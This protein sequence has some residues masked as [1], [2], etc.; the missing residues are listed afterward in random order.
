VPRPITKI[1]RW[2]RT[3]CASLVAATGILLPGGGA[4]A[5][6]KLLETENLQ[7]VWF[8]PAAD[9]LA[10]YA[11]Q[12]FLNS[13]AA[14]KARFGYQPD[15][16]VAI[17]LQDFVDAG[18]AAAVMGAPRNRI[19]IDIAPTVLSFE[20]FSPGERL[21][22]LANHELVHT[23]VG[24][25]ASSE[26]ARARRWLGGK[27]TPIAEHPET[28]LYNYL[29]NPRASSPRW[30][31][32]GSAVFMETWYGGGLGRAQGGYDEMV[33]RAMVRDGARFYDPLG[34]VSEGTE[35]DFQTGANAYLYGTRFVSYLA[36]IYGPD[37]VID[38]LR[39]ADGTERYY[40]EDFERVFSLPLDQAWQEWITWEQGFQQAN[41]QSVRQQPITPLHEVARRG[42]GA[43][44]RAYLSKDGRTLYAAARFPGRVPHLVSIDLA[45][46]KVTE[47][48][49]LRGSLPYKV[50]SLAYDGDGQVLYFTSNNAGLRNLLAYDLES[51][52]TRTLLK[53][54]RIGDIAYNPADRSLWG[55]RTNNGFVMI[56][57]VPY[58]YTEWQTLYVYPYGEVAF[59]LDVSPDGKLVSVSLAGPDGERSGV[60]VMQLRVMEAERLLAGDAVPVHR[61][62][63]GTAMPESFVFSK[64]SRYLYGSSYYTGVSNIYRYDLALGKLEAVSN[65]EVG[66]FRPL[67]IDDERVLVFHYTADGFVPAII[68]PEPTEDLSAITFLGEQIATRHPVVQQ[69]GAG[70][71]SQVDYQAQVQRT[72][73]YRPLRELSKEALYP[74]VEGYKDSVA[75]GA[76]ARFSDPLGLSGVSTTLSYSPDSSLES[77]ERLHAQV[78]FRHYPWRVGL[79]WHAG[80]FYDLFGPIKRSREGYSGFV[81]YERALV[82]EPPEELRLVGSLAYY[83]DLD[84]L[85]GFQN[86]DSPSDSLGEMEVGVVYR[87]P[88]GSAGKVDDEAGHLW[89]LLVRANE[90]GGDVTPGVYGQFDVGWPL[91][92]P[93]SSI[94]LRTG[95]GI[96]W[97]DRDD[98]LANAFFGGFRNNY[99]DSREPQRYRTLL[100]MPGFEIDALNGRTFG[101]AMLEWNLPP[102]RF[103]S[104]GTP[105]FY[106]KWLR[107]AVFGTALVTNPDAASERVDAYNV[108]LQF[109]VQLHVLNRLPM[110][111]SLGYA[112]GYGGRGA[113]ENEFMLSLKV[114]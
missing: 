103:D 54:A 77:R 44:S 78:E 69:W 50:T 9:Y 23:V 31:Q 13:L 100:A 83:G 18:N 61:F 43:L 24:D 89:A 81:A 40:A 48:T 98:P 20:T 57:R 74:I 112:H 22:T 99:V 114:L 15:G 3:A 56:V 92:L 106:A 33:F 26:D 21:Y 90:A 37:K 45:S 53:G 2:A 8:S 97:G 41:L 107:P 39:R 73:T 96:A 12:S 79:K 17:L 110:M 70:P 14:Q 19:Y 5:E 25:Q 86:I 58:P 104:A 42:L 108:G 10:P 68:R 27:V 46:G 95:A 84:A 102:L 59:D 28:I 87:Y 4:R 32:E 101:K 55:L 1:I 51:G 29:T 7:L 91:R 109:D 71:P 11:A 62:E 111:L 63:L 38:W 36:L 93:H 66:Y 76:Y 88:R 65:A 47:L 30:Y 60:Q 67:P 94:W 52:D 113:G 82:F 6:I 75:L 35:V 105:G 72:T 34:L 85:P 49:E 16:R 80:D 64:D